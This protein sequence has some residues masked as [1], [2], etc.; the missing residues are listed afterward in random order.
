M[1]VDGDHHCVGQI[2]LREISATGWKVFKIWQYFNRHV[3]VLN[4]VGSFSAIAYL[5][6]L[7]NMRLILFIQCEPGFQGW[8][9][10][11]V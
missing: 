8:Q 6:L 1:I 7:T 5:G 9:C 3:L 10:Q 2:F 4:A 11:N